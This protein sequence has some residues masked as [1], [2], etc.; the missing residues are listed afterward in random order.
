MGV[1]GQ[2]HYPTA[3]YSWGKDPDTH[4]IG[5]WIGLR[6]DL[7]TEARGDSFTSDGNRSSVVQHVVRHCTDCSTRDPVVRVISSYTTGRHEGL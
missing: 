6:A 5:G 1:N 2:R 3:I 7:D 4:W